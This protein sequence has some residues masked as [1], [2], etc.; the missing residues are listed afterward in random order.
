MYDTEPVEE[1]ISESF[2]SDCFFQIDIGNSDYTDID[3]FE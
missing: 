3:W 2:V 1:V